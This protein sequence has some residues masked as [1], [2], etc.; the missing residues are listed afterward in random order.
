MLLTIQGA[1]TPILS[2]QCSSNHNFLKTWKSKRRGYSSSRKGQSSWKGNLRKKKSFKY[3]KKMLAPMEALGWD[4]HRSLPTD[5]YSNLVRFFY[6]NLKV[7][8]LDNIEYTIDSRVKGKNIVLNPIILSEITGIA[9]VGDCIFINK[10][11]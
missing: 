2:H 8:N 11:S 1:R 10:P 6:C 5:V 7:R 9:N 3:Y 4:G